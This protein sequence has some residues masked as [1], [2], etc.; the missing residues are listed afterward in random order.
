MILRLG[1]WSIL[2]YFCGIFFAVVR[3]VNDNS[4]TLSM[5]E[6]NLEI[7]GSSP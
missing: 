7:L 2:S 1:L 4:Q 6:L 5:S 3:M